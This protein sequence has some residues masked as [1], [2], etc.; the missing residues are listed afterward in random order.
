MKRRRNFKISTKNKSYQIEDSPLYKL[1]SKKKLYN[2]LKSNSQSINELLVDDGNYAVFNQIMGSKSRLIEHPSER[3]DLIHT[4]IASLLCRI[5]T[6][7]Y[8]HSGLKGRSHVTN[9][10]AHI[11]N[12]PVLTTDVKS[13]FPSTS[14]RKVFD[15]F[16]SILECSPDVSDVLAKLC[17]FDG[18]I[19]TGSRISM[20]L[21]FW[22]NICMFE[23][24][25]SLSNKHS[26]KMT[27]YVD[28]ITFS[29][30]DVNFLFKNVAKKIISRHGHLMHPVKTI[31]YKKDDV[32]II[33]GIVVKDGKIRI[34]NSQHKAIYQ[35]MEQW[36]SLSFVPESLSNRLLGRLNA[37]SV[38]EPKLK[39]KA[40]TFRLFDSA[41]RVL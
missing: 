24:L 16:Y 7:D 41:K 15:F 28:D 11:G 12:V 9:A 3:L 29:G 14:Q 22:A 1:K 20:P 26:I 34:K 39:D 23:E 18:H 27:V 10:K 13:F 4:R 21:A 38:V 36:K 6:P 25:N 30:T 19:P 17:T 33:T 5:K 8:L 2:L 37:L 35:D 32:K 40:K 31:L